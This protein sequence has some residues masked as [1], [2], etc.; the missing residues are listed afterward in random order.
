MKSFHLIYK[1]QSKEIWFMHMISHFWGSVAKRNII[2]QIPN[3]FCSLT[4][5]KFWPRTAKLLIITPVDE[6]Y[7][8]N[9]QDPWNFNKSLKEVQSWTWTFMMYRD[10]RLSVQPLGKSIIGLKLSEEI[11]HCLMNEKALLKL[12]QIKYLGTVHS[13]TVTWAKNS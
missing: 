9:I 7:I 6:S 13:S 12:T 1:S 8:I 10:I 2:I 11:R 5:V 4:G 3:T